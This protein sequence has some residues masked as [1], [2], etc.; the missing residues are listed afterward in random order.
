VQEFT[1]K[2]VNLKVYDLS[3]QENLRTSWKYYYDS[4]NG[5]I[6]VFDSTFG[7]SADAKQSQDDV[8]EIRETIHQVLQETAEQNIPVLFLAN[9]QDLEY[10]VSPEKLWEELSLDRH[11]AKRKIKIM[12]TVGVTGQGLDEAFTWMVDSITEQE[13]NKAKLK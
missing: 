11:A 1:F 12:P 5:L 13:Q 7:K 8:T 3:G 10:S 6:F 4:I 9:K 2:N